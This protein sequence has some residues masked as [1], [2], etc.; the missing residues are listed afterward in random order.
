MMEIILNK[1]GGKLY[2]SL[3]DDKAWLSQ[4]E[5]I[6]VFKQGMYSYVD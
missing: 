5:G 6:Y 3:S 2:I 4:V 1:I